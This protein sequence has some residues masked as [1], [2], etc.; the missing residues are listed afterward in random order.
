[1]SSNRQSPADTADFDTLFTWGDPTTGA[2]SNKPDMWQSARLYLREPAPEDWQQLQ[3]S[4]QHQPLSLNRDTQGRL[5]KRAFTACTSAAL[6][7]P[8]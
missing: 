6:S 5:L 7:A 8:P 2:V 4:C 3:L 1:M